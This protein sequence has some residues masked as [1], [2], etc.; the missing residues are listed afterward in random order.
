MIFVYNVQFSDKSL[1]KDSSNWKWNDAYL[2]GDR[3]IFWDKQCI[4]I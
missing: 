1:D 4:C 2:D 3:L